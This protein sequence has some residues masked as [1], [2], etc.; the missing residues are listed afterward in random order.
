MTKLVRVKDSVGLHRNVDSGAIVNSS[1]IDYNKYIM[2]K[3]KMSSEKTRIKN[4]EQDV[5]EIKDMLRQLLSK[6]Q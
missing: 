4:L 6:P 1:N 2:Q 5:M 3:E